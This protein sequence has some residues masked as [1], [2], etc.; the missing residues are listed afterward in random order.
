M[1]KNL[2]AKVNKLSRRI[3][4][5]TRDL[6]KIVLKHDKLRPP[7][8]VEGAAKWLESMPIEDLNESLEYDRGIY[9]DRLSLP[10][11]YEKSRLRR[12]YD[13]KTSEIEAIISKKTEVE[14]DLILEK[15]E[16]IQSKLEE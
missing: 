14:C 11:L 3:S 12:L 10:A 9:P 8:G 6:D 15:I 13:Q 1:K 5:L 7:G 4:T 16:N 2:A